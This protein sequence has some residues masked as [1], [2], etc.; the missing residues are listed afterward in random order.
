MRVR[1]FA[2]PI[3]LNK[4]PNVPYTTIDRWAILY[5]HRRLGR[6]SPVLDASGIADGLA[7]NN[8]RVSAFGVTGTYKRRPPGYLFKVKILKIIF[9]LKHTTMA[10]PARM[11]IKQAGIPTAVVGILAAGGLYTAYSYSQPSN[12]A[13]GGGLTGGLK[14][15]KSEDVNHNTKRL[16]FSFPRPDDETGLTYVCKY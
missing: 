14:L 13:F 11:T 12:K 10:L 15:Q 5:E 1:E 3:I 4:I 16:R 9:N 8:D 2:Y 7:Y 6:P